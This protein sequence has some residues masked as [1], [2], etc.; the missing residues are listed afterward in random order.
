MLFPTTLFSFLVLT[1]VFASDIC[2]CINVLVIYPFFIR[3]STLRHGI[4]I[5]VLVSAISMLSIILF[6]TIFF[7]VTFSLASIIVA[8]F[9]II[10]IS[11]YVTLCVVPLLCGFAFPR[12]MAY[13]SAVVT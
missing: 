4:P 10:L 3:I 2:L 8:G 1:T 9:T 11:V 13:F 7:I 5:D 6:V 12:V